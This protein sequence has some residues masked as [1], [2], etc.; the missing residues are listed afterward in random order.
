[1]R[2]F[3]MFVNIE[4]KLVTVIGGGKI[5]TRRVE[6]LLQ[7]GCSIKVIAPVFTPKLKDYEKQGLLKLIER[8][9]IES[10]CDDAFIL[11]AVTN[12][13]QVNNQIYQIAKS[14]D[15]LVNVCDRKEECDFY[16]PG[17]IIKDEAVV[18][19]TCNGNNHSLA[20][21]V[22]NRIAEIL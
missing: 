17:V 3:P 19:V 8:E 22:K 21:E 4:S 7:F 6:T 2:Y 5:A 16:F 1:M 18:G 10:D 11:F 15:I 9:Y 20:Q 12:N 13:R 14:K